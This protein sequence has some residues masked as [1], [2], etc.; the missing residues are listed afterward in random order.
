MKL[1]SSLATI[2]LSV[3]AASVSAADFIS[4]EPGKSG[5]GAGKHVLLLAGDEEYRSEEGLPMLAKILAKRH[6]F[7]TTVCF[8]VDS[9]GTID[10]NASESLSHPEALDSA[11]AIVM[12]LRFRHYPDAVMQKFDAAVRRGVPIIALR[13]STHAFNKLK[14]E[15]AAYN[16][17][18]KDVLGE[19]WV[20]HWGSHKKEATRGVIEKG[21]TDEPILR[22]V[23][24][25]FG[26]SDVYEA[27]PP[28]DARILLRGRVLKGMN[29]VDVGA[30]YSKKR[31]TDKVEQPVN[32]PMMPIA[33]TREQ[34]RV[35]GGKPA[36]IFCTTMGAATDLE[37]E[38][39]RRL[40]VNAVYWGLD[41]NI[42]K[43][44]DVQYVDP[45][46]PSKYGFKGYRKGIRPEDHAFGKSLPP[47]A[48]TDDLAQ[49]S[50]AA[51]SARALPPSSLPL[52]LVKGEKIALVG[53]STAER[54]NLFGTFETLLHHR[55][56]K[57]ELV[58]R[59]FARPADE[60]AV[61]QR[62][63]DYTKIDDPLKVFSPDTFLC[64][65]GFNESFAGPGGVEKFKADYE[66]FLDEYAKTYA[67]DAAG[68]KPRFV[69]VSPIAF[70][71]T[72]DALLSDG[73]AENKNLALYAEA[74]R[75]VAAKRGL[76]YV[77][78]FTPTLNA[79]A[80]QSGMQYTINGCH[81]NAA[82]DKLIG[83]LLDHGLFG[84]GNSA[85]AD[86]ALVKK[87]RAAVNDK[88]WVHLQDYRMLNGWY[89]YGG[90][91]TWD[92]ET[93]PREY[94][95]IRNMAAVRD[96][97]VWDIAQ[98]KP[99][100]EVPDDSKTG[101]L[102]TPP[103]RFGEPRQKYSENPEGGPTILP[104]DELIKTCTM[105]P[106]FEMKLFADEERFPEIAKPVQMTF[107]AKG[108]L[109]VS[110][111]PSYP[112]WKP[113]DPRPS[114]KLVILEDTDGDGSAD[115]STVFYDQL[116]C[117]T[118]FEFFNGGVL[119][120]NQPRI[121]WLKDNDGDDRAD[122]VV[123][124][125][126]GWATEDTHH[127]VGAFESSPGGLLHMLEGVSMS[128]A[129]ETP[130]GPF[131]NFGSS[132]CYIVDPR[133]WKIEHFNTP[134][135]GNPWCY[136]FNE[137][138]QGFCGDGTGANQHWDTPLSGKQYQ[139]RKGM[140]AVF[141]TEG[142]RPVVGSEFLV[143]RQFPDDVQGQ[144]IYACVINMNGMPRW[145]FSDDGAGYKGTRV[146]YN[147]DDPA[148]PFD[149][150]KST[151][152]HFRP[153]DPQI[154]PDGALWFGDWA[155]P[156]IGHMQ[157]SQRDP[158]RDHV[159][160]RIYRMYYK[161][162]PLVK[163]VTQFGKSL[164]ELFEQL[165]TYEWRTRYHVR[166]EIQ[167]RP[168]AEV[169][170]A[171]ESWLSGLDTSDPAYDRLRCEALWTQQSSHCVN[172]ELLKQVLAAKTSDARA[173][174][175]RV[176]ADERD[177]LPAAYELLVAASL[178][179]APRVR[180]E[181]I[182]GLS[183]FPTTAA[184]AAVLTSLKSQPVDSFIQYTAEAALGAN[185]AAWRGGYLKGE[186]AANDPVGKKLIESIIAQDKKG[187]ELLPYLQILIGK[188]PHSA[189]ERNKALT[190]LSDIRGGN[191][192]NGKTVFRRSC[193]ACHKVYG[194]GADFG[195]QMDG[196][197]DNKGP[198]GKRLTKFKI[199]E[200]IIDPNAE[201]DPKYLSTQIV[202]DDGRIIT[203][204]IIS[205]TKDEVVIFDGKE[206]RTIAVS[207]IE[208]R[209]KLKQSS[210]PEGLAATL[211]PVE[212]LDL[213]AFLSSLK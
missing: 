4:Y 166:R 57:S 173:A 28:A 96:R 32:D 194:E 2:V 175:A 111:M 124:V 181:A 20:S 71:P 132:G 110:T 190:A 102:F 75:A 79:F 182:R 105:P 16:N 27:Y 199:L 46:T 97:R 19:T 183:F 120:V 156:L 185:L 160:G 144:F 90:R 31:S 153:V 99:V 58:F 8:S 193:T 68:S 100:S 11:D 186:L 40:V 200:S 107:D 44:T 148:T 84:S 64:F 34:P 137:W 212:L 87:L 36:R 26:D 48:A 66:K 29:P 147:P 174:A 177:R 59:N 207:S 155:N 211:A 146:R 56:P 62:A 208:D 35:P 213:L 91:R 38:G 158:N 10:P 103:T 128:T 180:A 184:A 161:D 25:V 125:L 12:L 169:I 135:Y 131:R 92:T 21:A 209:N 98:G 52:Q 7:R 159:H 24:D 37:S 123:H 78:L 70:E 139:G 104:P 94:M 85:I 178:D 54:M 172:V 88:S 130:W 140:N 67:R 154:G 162:K 176:A 60:V 157:Y 47:P 113:G 164:P 33:W 106:G 23:I 83:E 201:I 115:K 203:G 151:D 134:G 76:A 42:P 126:D 39:L 9:D 129:V 72:G 93:F 191:A 81:A 61:R 77:D 18:G 17:F 187:A 150:L 171:L 138:G 6:G 163:P 108:R 50:V 13:T 63:N 80:K 112:Q 119:V 51:P 89:V 204:L 170:A 210:M 196:N 15:Y 73:V 168:K 109:W 149:L 192:E 205:E 121:V 82:G 136:V 152:K 167:A 3:L 118:G 197:P 165:R 117:P 188:D 30:D 65:F 74:V 86:A 145:T 45:Y 133:T 69:L 127:T 116:H 43:K 143:T 189:E 22:G 14:G 5:S 53:N 179:P 142:M 114:D 101:E 141:P 55:F 195:P 1:I 49:G 95:K 122:E 41:R 206:K 198:V 202:T